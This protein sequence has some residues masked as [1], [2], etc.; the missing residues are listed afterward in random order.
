MKSLRQYK[1]FAVKQKQNFSNEVHN[2]QPGA[3]QSLCFPLPTGV[4]M[5]KCPFPIFSLVLNTVNFT[6]SIRP[7][8]AGNFTCPA[9]ES[10]EKLLGVQ[11][12]DLV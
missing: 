12:E 7:S 1:K 4:G 3:E 8:I 2:L 5:A 9:E 6:V 11:L 10:Y